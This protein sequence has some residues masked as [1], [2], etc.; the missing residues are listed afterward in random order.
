M[1]TTIALSIYIIY[2][3]KYN[4]HQNII[5][6]PGASVSK[7]SIS[8]FRINLRLEGGRQDRTAR[9]MASWFKSKS[10]AMATCSSIGWPCSSSTSIC[11]SVPPASV[12]ESS[13][14]RLAFISAS[15]F[16]R[17]TVRACGRHLRFF[18]SPRRSTRV[19]SGGAAFGRALG[20]RPST[21]ARVSARVASGAFADG[22]GSTDGLLAA[23]EDPRFLSRRHSKL[24]P[25]PPRVGSLRPWR[26]ERAHL[27]GLLARERA[28]A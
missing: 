25:H 22:E 10:M 9:R 8:R 23:L 21:G 26:F 2:E 4:Y 1:M 3:Y 14:L 12:N 20:R 7:I 5:T 24:P 28:E 16:S 19:N 18:L 11:E 15:L 17:F 13:P 27:P 6:M